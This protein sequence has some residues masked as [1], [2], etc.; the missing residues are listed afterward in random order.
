MHWLA[1]A[2]GGSVG[3]MCRYGIALAL[4][5]QAGKFPIATLTVN[6]LGSMCLA[7]LFVLI[8][9]KAVLPSIWRQI[10]MVGFFGA[11]TT[12][13]TF[14]LESLQL[15]QAGQLKLALIYMLS[16]VSACIVA[17]F[18]GYNLINKIL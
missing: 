4:P 5:T 11:F 6:V 9:E 10:L 8:T 17:A 16:S 1:V 14:S 7:M 3:A 13:S 18:S 15:L 2:L 12:F